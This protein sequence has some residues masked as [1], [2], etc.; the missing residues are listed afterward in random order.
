MLL[1]AVMLVVLVVV[2]EG[3][4]RTMVPRDRFLSW[5]E[6][7][8]HMRAARLAEG[9]LEADETLGHRPVFD[10][11]D[12]DAQGI[13]RTSRKRSS[14]GTQTLFLGDSV[15]RRGTLIQGLR[16]FAPEVPVWNA[17][18]EAWCPVQEVDSYLQNT[19]AAQPERLV[20]AFHNNDF[21]F[22]PVA[23]W[24]GDTLAIC[25]PGEVCE[26]W[27]EAY[28]MSWLYRLWVN[29][30]HPKLAALPNP[31]AM[32]PM[33]ESRMSLLRESARED[34]IEFD[35]LL[36]PLF[37]PLDE[38]DEGERQSRE[39]AIALF[40]RLGLRWIDL[41]EPI[42]Q[43]FEAGLP[44]QVM[45][46]DRWHPNSEAGQLM[47]FHALQQG[48]FKEWNG[49][50]R[51]DVYAMVAGGDQVQ[52]LRFDAGAEH[53]GKPYRVLGSARGRG[54]SV[55]VQGAKLPLVADGYMAKTLWQTESLMEG[56]AGTLDE[57]GRAVISVRGPDLSRASESAPLYHLAV[58]Y[59]ESERIVLVSNLV[60]LVIAVP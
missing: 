46:G 6:L 27:P 10:G 32:L 55:E 23:L 56:G 14:G 41:L 11:S 5:N 4:V 16:E 57:Q 19:R 34:G 59:D 53:A 17:G 58:V 28:R 21:A 39:L 1:S 44:V 18:V 35:V 50:L 20:L 45:R 12:Y 13:L 24:Q 51:T 22:T 15:T 48:L 25:V 40:E 33:V 37:A 2:A 30:R 7:D 9:V 3:V 60:P 36:L 8:N 29:A 26:F 49:Q 54:R 47:A 43:M 42:K 38:W 52:E 31:Q